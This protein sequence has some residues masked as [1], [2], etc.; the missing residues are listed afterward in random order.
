M[1]R[2]ATE[3]DAEALEQLN[4]AFNGPGE[5]NLAHIRASLRENR[6]E[7]VVVDEEGGTLTGFLCLQIRRS[8]CYDACVPEITELYVRPEYR[9]QGIARRMLLFAE[10]HCQR[11]YSCQGLDLLTGDDNR[12]AQ[13][14]YRSLGYAPDGELHLSKAL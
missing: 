14:V 13:A 10:E 12:I 6:Q 11:Q 7:A 2:L 8:F 9:R 4:I 5:T 1:I 3:T